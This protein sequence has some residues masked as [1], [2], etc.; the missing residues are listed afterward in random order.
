[1]A[2]DRQTPLAQERRTSLSQERQAPLA[3]KQ[4]IP[5]ALERQ[6]PLALGASSQNVE[7]EMA[8]TQTYAES[9]VMLALFEAQMV[10]SLP[11][12]GGPLGG[13]AYAAL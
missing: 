13:V 8:G 5:M 12:I 3:Q 2:L 6:T 1:M 4:Q 9:A 10:G 11:P 7:S